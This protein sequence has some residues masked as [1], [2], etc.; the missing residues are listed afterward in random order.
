ML[1]RP[2]PL[3]WKP[4]DCSSDCSAADFASAASAVRTAAAL[5]TVVSTYM[6]TCAWAT[7][8]D[9]QLEM[10]AP[11]GSLSLRASGPA[12]W[13]SQAVAGRHESGHL[14]SATLLLTAWCPHLNGLGILQQ[15]PPLLADA[16]VLRHAARH[17]LQA[18]HNA[19]A[20]GSDYLAFTAAHLIPSPV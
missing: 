4:A 10:I 20:A 13:R 17:P 3:S 15:A 6:G 8:G 5:P 14:D 1:T 11:G 12:H 16:G 7:A 19:S 9:K 2:A 18:S